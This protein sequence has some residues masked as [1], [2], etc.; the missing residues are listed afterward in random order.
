[1]RHFIYPKFDALL[2]E[3][4]DHLTYSEWVAEV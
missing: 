1:M 2:D 3:W 4:L